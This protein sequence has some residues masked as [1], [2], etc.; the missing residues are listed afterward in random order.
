IQHTR[1]VL[2]HF[3]TE[4]LTFVAKGCA[5][6]YSGMNADRDAQPG[7]E[8]FFLVVAWVRL[9]FNHP[10]QEPVARLD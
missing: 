1:Q 7:G 5:R 3:V 2:H 8:S 6:Q 4:L 9:T 10:P